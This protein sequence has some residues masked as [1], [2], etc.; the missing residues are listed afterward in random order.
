MEWLDVINKTSRY[1][2]VAHTCKTCLH[3]E[4]RQS[5]LVSERTESFCQVLSPYLR[6]RPVHSSGQCDWWMKVK[7]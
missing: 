1:V 6:D 2:P 7:E 5:L 4:E 3:Y